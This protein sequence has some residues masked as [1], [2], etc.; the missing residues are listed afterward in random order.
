MSF[1]Q[2]I[3]AKVDGLMDRAA[4]YIA[5]YKETTPPDKNRYE[6]VEVRGNPNKGEVVFLRQIHTVEKDGAKVEMTVGMCQYHIYEELQAGKYKHVFVEGFDEDLGP[7]D[8]RRTG[9][10]GW[11]QMVK[12]MF[13]EGMPKAPSLPQLFALAK[14]GAPFIYA[15]FNPDVTLHRTQYHDEDKDQ[16]NDLLMAEFEA[17]PGTDPKKFDYTDLINKFYAARE[18]SAAREVMNYLQDNPGAKVALVYGIG[19]QF[20]DDFEKETTPPVLVSISF[21]FVMGMYHRMI[22]FEQAVRKPR[23]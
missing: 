1:L 14:L 7:G 3:N 15:Y 22:A 18:T 10:E 21:P 23:G 8:P 6:K 9:E 12:I 5:G 20:K 17:H 11:S 13:P 4:A 16:R 2:S 19:H